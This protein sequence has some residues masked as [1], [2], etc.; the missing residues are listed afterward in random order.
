MALPR[1]STNSNIADGS[2]RFWLPRSPGILIGRC[3]PDSHFSSGIREGKSSSRSLT[4]QSATKEEP[5][6]SL[7]TPNRV[8][9]P[10]IIAEVIDL[11][12]RSLVGARWRRHLVGWAPVSS[13]GAPNL[14]WLRLRHS[15]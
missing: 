8:A 1:L 15:Q 5:C 14:T 2:P 6:R 9:D 11:R 7:A 13:T 3:S 12:N 4:A 10:A